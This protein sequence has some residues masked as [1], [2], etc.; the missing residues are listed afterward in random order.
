MKT[1]RGWTVASYAIV[2]AFLV[3]VLV[4][5]AAVVLNSFKQPNDIFSSTLKL[6]FSPT[7]DNYSK[8]L[9][10]LQFQDFL[11]NS[12]VVAAGSTVLS[13]VVGVPAAYALARLPLRGR[14]LWAGAILFTRMVPAVALVVPMYV[15]FQRLELLGSY[16]ALIAAH[17]TFN[18]PIVVWM[19]RSFFEE[20]PPDL[21]EAALVDGANRLGAFIRVA[22]PLTAPG[23]AA[24]S[25]L[26]LLFSWNEFLFALVLSGR[27]TQ[28]VPI[29]V[30]SF[31][32][33]VSVDWGGS[34]AAAVLAML[35]VFVLGLAA[36]RFLVRG[37]TF[38]AVKG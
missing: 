3:G 24:T 35:P 8:V 17:T 27:G 5:I 32:G 9:G 29:G 13:I 7:L 16:T 12:T 1:N 34:S 20:L 23:L 6:A 10:Q 37:L 38:G 22:V 26:C 18:L 25:V 21:E 30:A 19:M 4:P 31:I 11:V 15:I 36:Q 28:T 33:T 14:E 2:A